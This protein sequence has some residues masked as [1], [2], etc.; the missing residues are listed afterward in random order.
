VRKVIWSTVDAFPVGGICQRT[1]GDPVELTASAAQ[2]P[3]ASGSVNK[4]AT[5]DVAILMSIS[6]DRYS[7]REFSKSRRRR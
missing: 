7:R 5:V 4:F 3:S 1:L 2:D 6:L